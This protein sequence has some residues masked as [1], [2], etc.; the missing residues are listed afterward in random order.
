M[1]PFC[2]VIVQEVLPKI[3]A[4]IARELVEK[5]GFT[6][7]LAAK[8]LGTTQPAISHYLREMR[9][10]KKGRIEKDPVLLGRVEK[11]AESLASGKNITLEFCEICRTVRERK[12]ICPSCTANCDACSSLC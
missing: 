8:K 4:I 11:L 7:E 2:E 10:S 6:Q 3:R 9:A 1:K 5:Y 12:I